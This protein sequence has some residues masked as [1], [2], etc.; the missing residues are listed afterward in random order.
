MK[1]HYFLLAL[2]ALFFATTKG[3]STDPSV[4]CNSNRFG[5]DSV[6]DSINIRVRTDIPFDT[7]LDWQGNKDTLKLDLYHYKN[8]LDTMNKRPLILFLYG[9]A[10]LTGDKSTVKPIC[11]ELAERGYVVAAINYRLGW[12]CATDGAYSR[13]KAV[14]R[15][16]Q[17]ANSAL[18]FLADRAGTYRIDTSWVFV[19][20]QSAGSGTVLNLNYIKQA[21]FNN[22]YP[23][24]KDTLGLLN[25]AGNPLAIKAI[26]NNWGGVDKQFFDNADIKPMISFHGL[27]DTV[28]PIGTDTD[29]NNCYFP[30]PLVMGSGSLHEAIWSKTCTQL[31]VTNG[32]HG[33]Y[34][35]NPGK[36]YR[37][38]MASAFF[39]GLFCGSCASKC[40]YYKV[41]TP[42]NIIQ[43]PG[44]VARF[45]A[46]VEEPQFSLYPNPA[47][48][49]LTIGG[50]TPGND[51]RLEVR[52]LSGRLLL[53][54]AQAGPVD[55]RTLSP[56]AYLVWIRNEHK[57]YRAKFIKQ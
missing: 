52:D 22:V 18:R 11:Q 24:I 5:A 38:S 29:E 55:V 20:G 45:G 7:V 49:Q 54:S 36:K 28:V 8:D 15:A 41:D 10:F 47:S 30:Q 19:G 21:E 57:Y 4:Y 53:S 31:F 34:Q 2:C 40:V 35:D 17:D 14:Y 13:I 9:G 43:W 44:L 42:C 6:I 32:G 48:D 3:Q 1:K 27:N 23:T 39:K 50:M 26:F 51:F 46:K 12:S 33:I 56:G 37:V 25:E 16:I